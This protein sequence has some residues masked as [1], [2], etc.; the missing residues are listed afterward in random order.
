MI[1]WFR[2]GLLVFVLLQTAACEQ[3][4]QLTTEPGSGVVVA[5]IDPTAGTT[6]VTVTVEQVTGQSSGVESAAT[7]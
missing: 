2:T 5:P 4:P 3:P 1:S 6:P 7:S